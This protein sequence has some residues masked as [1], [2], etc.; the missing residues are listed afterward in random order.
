MAK[1]AASRLPNH[2][3]RDENR[4]EIEDRAAYVL[5]QTSQRQNLTKPYQAATT[6]GWRL[7]PKRF[8]SKK[9]L[10]RTYERVRRVL[11]NI[12]RTQEQHIKNLTE[13]DQ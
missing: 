4:K 12:S 1:D 9:R 13:A 7:D 3:A 6:A 8:S 5:R 2:H 11:L 10:V